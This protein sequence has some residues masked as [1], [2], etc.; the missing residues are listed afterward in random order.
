MTSR[1]IKFW[2]PLI[3]LMSFPAVAFA[4]AGTPLMWAG[5]FH[6]IIGNA[7][8]GI[9]EGLILAILFRQKKARCV[10]IMIAANYF[11]A[12]AGGFLLSWIADSRQVDLYNAW[13]WLWIMVVVT[14]F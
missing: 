13:Q 5:A 9:A 14:Y 7:I 3:A 4:D 6:L 2:P 1:V 10:L 8:I 11:S 12:W